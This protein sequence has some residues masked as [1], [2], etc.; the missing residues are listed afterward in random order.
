VTIAC[1]L[2]SA[3]IGRRNFFT[4]VWFELIWLGVC[5]FF[6]LG[7]AA[8]L[9][10]QTPG[11]LSHC[12][13]FFICKGLTVMLVFAWLSWFILTLSFVFI[14]T[15]SLYQHFSKD[16][17]G[18][19]RTRVSEWEGLDGR[20]TWEGERRTRMSRWFGGAPGLGLGF[21]HK[22]A[23]NAT[24]N[25]GVNHNNG[26]P[27]IRKETTEG[28]SPM[29]P[30]PFYTSE[31]ASTPSTPTTGRSTPNHLGVHFRDQEDHFTIGDAG[32]AV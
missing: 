16:R 7:G 9:H 19:W 10:D 25:D 30:P 17:H 13:A 15:C 1:L 21:G 8:T 32:H 31:S 28:A 11:L 26:S 2:I 3:T 14:L 27:R 18:V 24:G 29:S 6:Y 23:K 22:E 5:W 4:H 20:K 12:G